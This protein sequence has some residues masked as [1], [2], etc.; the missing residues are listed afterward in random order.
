MN[1]FVAAAV[2]LVVAGGLYWNLDSGRIALE[3]AP[4]LFSLPLLGLAVIFGVRAWTESRGPTARYSSFFAGLAA[5]VG[6]YALARLA[7]LP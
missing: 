2:A 1:P 5:G 4:R 7:L 6:G 3:P